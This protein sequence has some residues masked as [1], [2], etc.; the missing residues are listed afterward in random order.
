MPIP[1]P[2]RPHIV[3][4]GASS[5]IGEALAHH[6]ASAGVRLA[7]T[8][9]DIARLEVV[10]TQCRS[11]GAEVS[12]AVVDVTNREAMERW[13]HTQDDAL[14][15][16]LVIA[17]AGISGGTS[18][19]VDGGAADETAEAAEAIFET[20]VQG[21]L[22]S[23]YPL[24]PR[25]RARKSGQI[26]VVSSLAGF[27]GLPG[28][29]AYSASKMAV[30]GWGEALRGWL[31][32]DGIKVSVICPGYVRSRITAANNFPMPG[33]M[34]AARAAR[35]IAVGLEKNRSRITFPWWFAALCWFMGM[36]S[37]VLTDPIYARLPKK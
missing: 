14:P 8:G 34:D 2:T 6:Y 19:G 31:E 24:I 12:A 10:A 30:R 26:A 3:I 32:S 29:P 5:G 7:L 36:L 37:P 28:A 15:V 16:T 35:I 11:Q 20:N 33:L 27:R 17:N 23:V 22:R 25:M 13:L 18:S 1:Q 9:R 4:T 21:V